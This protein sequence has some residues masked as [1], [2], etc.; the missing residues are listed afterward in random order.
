MQTVRRRAVHCEIAARMKK[1][2]SNLGVARPFCVRCMSRSNSVTHKP[3]LRK[4]SHA[5][6]P[7][8]AT[9]VFLQWL[10]SILSV[11]LWSWSHVT[12]PGSRPPRNSIIAVLE[13]SMASRIVH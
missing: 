1:D 13:L 5:Y 6:W 12:L 7:V 11:Y 4:W 2:G 9:Y 10:Q 8:M 3:R